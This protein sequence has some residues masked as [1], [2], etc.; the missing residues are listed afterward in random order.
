MLASGEK[1][2]ST[3]LIDYPW[4]E[5]GGGKCKRGANRHYNTRSVRD[6]PRI[7]LHSG[8]FNPT[9]NAHLYFWVTNNFI[10][11]GLWVIRQ[12]GFRYVTCITWPKPRAGLGQ[13]FRG[14]TEHCFYAEKDNNNASGEDEDEDETEHMFFAV[15]GHGFDP[16]VKTDRKDLNT[17]MDEWEHPQRKH[18]AKPPQ[19]YDL[20][21]ARS[22][23]RYL[24]MCHRCPEPGEYGYPCVHREGWTYWGDETIQ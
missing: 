12:I 16:N 6:A 24:E 23:G 18:S 14:K 20:I 15:R 19:Q 8:V 11:E 10:P 13:Y 5:N 22:K 4:P 1:E 17:L 3:I 2:Y 9:D 7:I 21:E